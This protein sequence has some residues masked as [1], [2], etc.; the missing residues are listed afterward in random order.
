MK[1]QAALFILVI[2]FQ[3]PLHAQYKIEMGLE[4]G[5]TR[6]VFR[7]NE[8]LNKQHLP[9]IAFSS[10]LT[11]QYNFSKYIALRTGLAFERKSTR[12]GG[13]YSEYAGSAFNFK[14]RYNFDYLVLPLLLRASLGEK[15][16]F[17]MGAGPFLAYL[18]KQKTV[19][20]EGRS[21]LNGLDN[22][23]TGYYKSLDFGITLGAGVQVPM[24]EKIALSFEVRN[25]LGMNDISTLPI[26]NNGTIKTNST[27]LLLGIVYKLKPRTIIK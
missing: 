24:K 8:F 6:S 21:H 23:N 12:V 17:S 26:S 20:T 9:A 7:G 11:F 27:Q 18:L 5:A 19:V 15:V 2:T 10:G 3:A 25:N 13:T 1:K 14:M 22:E 16:K 4:G